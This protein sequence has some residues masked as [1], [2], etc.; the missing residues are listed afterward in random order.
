MAQTSGTFQCNNQRLTI[1]TQAVSVPVLRKA[2]DNFYEAQEHPSGDCP[3]F[4]G[5][6]VSSG[7]DRI[8]AG[9]SLGAEAV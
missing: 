6:A 9:T 1:Y 2:K 3:V 8:N 5:I 7:G 4:R